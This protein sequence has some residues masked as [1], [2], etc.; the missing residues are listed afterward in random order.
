MK[1]F[2]NYRLLVSVGAMA[3]ILTAGVL[4]TNIA[5]A[6][7]WPPKR[8]TIVIPH[9]ASGGQSVTTRILGKKWSKLLGTKFTYKN[10]KGAGT[11]IGVDYFLSRPKNGA[12]MVSTN[13]A[14]SAIMYAQQKPPWNYR[15]LLLPIGIYAVDP[16]V[17]FVN[18]DSPHKSFA[19]VIKASKK[20]KMTMAISSWASEDN[21]QIHQ[22]MQATG[23]MFEVIPNGVSTIAIAQVLGGN[24]DVGFAK[25]SNVIRGGPN[26]RMLAVAQ[27]TNPVPDL[28]NN[29][30]TA[31]QAANTKT[32][33]VASYRGF[34]VHKS[35]ADK[36]P[37]HVKRLQATLEKAKK[38]PKTIKKLKK[39]GIAPGLMLTMS[40]DYIINQVQGPLIAAVNK[41]AAIFKAPCPP[42]CKR[43]KK[44]KKKKKK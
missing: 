21:L 20:K 41:N 28:T 30:V 24:Q 1:S 12:A 23:A 29:A 7:K 38:D 9:G 32:I 5:Y 26:L 39:K 35:W 43:K 33:S 8:M 6:E 2:M 40:S 31:D 15:E 10:K 34:L 16:G 25:V 22:V 37:K 18:K 36:N 17:Y 42:N 19:S 3:G 13:L 27:P 14:S 11:R 4:V 44:K